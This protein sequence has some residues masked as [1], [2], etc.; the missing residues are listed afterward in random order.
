MLICAEETSQMFIFRKQILDTALLWI[1]LTCYFECQKVGQADDAAIE[2]STFG[3]AAAKP[4]TSPS[5]LKRLLL[6]YFCGCQWKAFPK[7]KG[8]RPKNVA[9]LQLGKR[10]M[11]TNMPFKLGGV[12]CESQ[13]IAFFKNEIIL[14]W[15]RW[16]GRSH[17]SISALPGMWYSLGGITAAHAK[18]ADTKLQYQTC[19]Q[20]FSFHVTKQL[21]FT[22][23]TWPSSK[24]AWA[25]LLFTTWR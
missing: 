3:W 17:G 11:H 14:H 12:E 5:L 21:Q 18:S 4:V 16:A 9:R 10:E 24:P 2:K 6:H 1:S 20:I 13:E 23:M 15:H 8:I 25:L 22:K 7:T 19:T